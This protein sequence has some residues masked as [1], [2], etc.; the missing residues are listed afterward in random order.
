MRAGLLLSLLW[1]G[2]AQAQAPARPMTLDD[3]LAPE[4]PAEA[5]PAEAV[6]EDPPAAETPPAEPEKPKTLIEA[7]AAA[8]FDPKTK[9]EGGS[10][11]VVQGQ[12]ALFHLDAKAGPVLDKVETG[13]LGAALPDGQSETY[14]GSG[15]GRI[16]LALDASPARKQSYMKVWNGLAAPITFELELAAIRKGQLMRRKIE[17]CAVPAGGVHG[18]AWP[19]PIIAVTV[20]KVALAVRG[21]TPCS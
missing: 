17:G 18:E 15:A 20:S 3:F 11:Q 19:D 2:V 7:L 21:A 10:V 5:P 4:P 6:P 14:K 1:A 16:G 8:G 12:R 9:V 13:K